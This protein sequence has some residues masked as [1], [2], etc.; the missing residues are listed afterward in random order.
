MERFKGMN[1]GKHSPAGT[2]SNNLL[3][4]MIGPSGSDANSPTR[5]DEADAGHLYI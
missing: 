4:P 5:L 1:T 3:Q 2:E